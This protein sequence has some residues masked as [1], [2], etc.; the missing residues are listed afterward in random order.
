MTM[1]L[2]ALSIFLAYLARLAPAQE[3]AA[4]PRTV[5]RAETQLVLV[6]AT[7]Q[8]KKGNPVHGLD[9]KDFRVWEDG[10]EQAVTSIS[11]E[12]S[13]V[14]PERSQNHYLVLFF[15]NVT[16]STSDQLAARRDAA[17]FVSAWAAPDRYMSVVDFAPLRITQGFTAMPDPLRQA[18]ADVRASGQPAAATTGMTADSSGPPALPGRGG[19]GRGGPPAVSEQQTLNQSPG[20][21]FAQL[22]LL[23]GLKNVAESL[24]TVRGRKALVLFTGGFTASPS[25]TQMAGAISACNQ[26]NVAVY[27]TNSASFKALAEETG[28]RVIANAN[29]LVG[30]LGHIAEEQEER[31]VLGYTPPESPVGSCHD[32]RV[33]VNRPGV[34]VL[35]RKGYCSAKPMG[36]LA[37]GATAKAMETH[38]AATSAGNLAASMQ[39][40]YFY[41]SANVARVNLAMEIASAGIKF[42]KAKGKPHAELHITGVAS[43][44]GGEVA[45]RFNDTVNLDFATTKE[46]DAFAKQPYHYEY[47]FDLTPGQYNLRVTVDA[48]GGISGNVEMPLSIAPWNGRGLGLSGVAFSKETHPVT[49]LASNLDD[50]L[51]EDRHRLIAGSH[52]IVPAGSNHFHRTDLSLVYLEIYDPLLAGPEPPAVTLRIRILDRLTGQL[53]ADLGAFSMANFIRPGNAVVP[54]AFNLPD[55]LAPGAYRL[56]VTARHSQ[57][58][59]AV[60]RTADFVIE[61]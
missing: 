17:R 57:E 48:G 51:L 6:D 26:A 43:K 16:L 21:P 19:R 31:Y 37:G 29:D 49:D 46:S 15:D 23:A 47:Q 9:A 50:S 4:P 39:L 54:A 7:V 55:S 8:D 40:P 24:S 44:A 13:G 18:L 42:D 30:Q 11:A 2:A 3:P 38:A 53:T 12:A 52:Q 5:I 20:S 27:T 41:S 60:V 22:D 25:G 33:A 56:E 32:L 14:S 10:K 58:N 36:L 45:G 35:A 61:N 1:R 28:G 34:D 59:D